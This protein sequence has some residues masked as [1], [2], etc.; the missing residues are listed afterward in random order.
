MSV[1]TDLLE[2]KA[3]LSPEQA[4]LVEQVIL[5]HVQAN[6]PP[7]FQGII[8]SV[9]GAGGAAGQTAPGGL[10]GLLGEAESLFGGR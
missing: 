5:E 2:Q 6:V 7:E 1:I 3:G 10:G 9:L 8:G 4:T